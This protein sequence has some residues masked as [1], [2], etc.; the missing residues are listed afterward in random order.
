[1]ARVCGLVVHPSV[2]PEVLL[3]VEHRWTVA[4]GLGG[5]V[6]RVRPFGVWKVCLVVGVVVLARCWVLR[7][8][9]P[10]LLGGGCRVFLE[11]LGLSVPP[12]RFV[13]G[14]RPC[15]GGGGRGAGVWWWGWWLS[16]L[17]VEN[18][19]VDASIFVAC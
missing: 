12:D 13:R 11:W 10:L 17:L 4:A 19:T 9:A 8:R 1:R 3:W 6:V 14:G 16:W 18:C 7:D 5:R 15:C 2:V